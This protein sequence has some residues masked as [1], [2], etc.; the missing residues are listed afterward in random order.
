[1]TDPIRVA[2]SKLCRCKGSGERPDHDPAINALLA[3]LDWCDERDL[4]GAKLLDFD[5][6]TERVR[7][8]I[9]YALGVE[10]QR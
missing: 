4:P 9:A 10:A 8:C 5:E 3:V 7:F 6:E 2:V 1:M